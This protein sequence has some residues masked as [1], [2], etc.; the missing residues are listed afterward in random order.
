M[1]NVRGVSAYFKSELGQ[2][3]LASPTVRREWSFN[4]VLDENAG[5]LLQGVIDCAFLEESCWVLVDYKTDRIMDEEAFRQRY[6]LQLE[7]YAR[8]LE[9]ITG[10]P[11]KEMWL[12]AIEKNKAYGMQ[13]IPK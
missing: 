1:L 7:W 6:A 10:L 12:Y 5:T 3:M 11:V 9:R 8:A 13:R 4:L 2:R